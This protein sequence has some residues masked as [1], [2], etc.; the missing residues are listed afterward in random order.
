M[1]EFGVIVDDIEDEPKNSSGGKGGDEDGSEKLKSRR[2][3]KG[4]RKKSTEEKEEEKAEGGKAEGRKSKKDSVHVPKE[5]W[6]QPRKAGLCMKYGSDQH[7]IRD[8]KSE[9]V[10]TDAKDA[11]GDS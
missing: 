9:A 2:R 11:K 7:R 3:R 8:C 5:L 6:D 10:T 4:K 1:S